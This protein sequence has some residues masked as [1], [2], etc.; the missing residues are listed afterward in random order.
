MLAAKDLDPHQ[1]SS[2]NEPPTEPPSSSI[3]NPF[4]SLGLGSILSRD[5]TSTK[6]N[7]TPQHQPNP[8]T[9]SQPILHHQHLP[10][11]Q[12]M[13]QHNLN[14]EMNSILNKINTNMYSSPEKHTTPT[15]YSSSSFT[16]PHQSQAQNQPVPISASIPHVTVPPVIAQ[17]TISPLITSRTNYSEHQQNFPNP[18]YH[19]H[20]NSNISSNLNHPQ[21]AQNSMVPQNNYNSHQNNSNHQMVNSNRSSVQMNC[22]TPNMNPG[23]NSPFHSKQN[24]EQMNVINLA[25]IR[26]HQII[27]SRYLEQENR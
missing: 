5:R 27:T 24:S 11:Q 10:V 9:P 18:I 16:G 26:N 22:V 4:A 23:I 20:T 19:S 2:Q 1:N 17:Q 25:S 14:L 7:P 6:I 15:Q 21:S 12:Q 8:P 3:L 13:H